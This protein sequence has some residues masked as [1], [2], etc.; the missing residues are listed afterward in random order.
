M[1]I[2]EQL[3]QE[4]LSKYKSV[5]AFTTAIQ[6]PYSTLD[7][8]FKRGISNA[9]I[10]T[11]LKVFG[12]LDLDIESIQ[13][14][15][16]QYRQN[17]HSKNAPSLSD[18]AME[19]AKDYDT[20]DHW[21]KKQ[22]RNV[23]DNELARMED[24]ARFLAETTPEPEPKIIPLYL[25]PVAA[26]IAS[27]IMG[28]DYE[29]YTLKPEDPQGAMFAIKVQ[30]DSMEPYFADTSTVFCNK[31]PIQDGDIGVF[32]VDGGAV[33]KQ[34]HRQGGIV[35]LFS[36]NRERADADVVLPSTSGRG[37]SCQGRV[38]T[39]RRYQLPGM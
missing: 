24:E 32:C 1:T 25:S 11:M 35:Y 34:Y 10:E 18:G 38:I 7:S 30:G 31:D 27:P 33:I 39:K 5:R 9:G 3:K 37:F 2:E 22:V 26:G 28:E 14:K 12:A 4:I 23:A 20:L 15:E 16:L 29:E 13:S 17:C 6:I 36:L 8:V 19:L 21:G